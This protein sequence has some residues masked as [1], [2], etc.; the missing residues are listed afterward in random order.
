[1]KIK[2]DYDLEVMLREIDEFEKAENKFEDENDSEMI[3]GGVERSQ[4]DSNNE[5]KNRG[6][7]ANLLPKFQK[8]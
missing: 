8:E 7:F 2:I 4:L 3:E 5:L 1:M 6:V